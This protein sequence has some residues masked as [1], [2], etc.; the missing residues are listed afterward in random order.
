MSQPIVS[1]IIPTKN[2]AATLG[3]CL[4]SIKKQTY[5]AAK[6]ELIVIDNFSSD[7]TPSLAKKTADIFIQKGPERSAQ[8]NYGVKKAHGKY[9]MIIDSDMQLAPEVIEQ[10]VEKIGHTPNTV[11]II[12]PEESFGEGFWAQC[13]QLERSFYVGVA[14][15]EAARF[16]KKTDFTAVGGYDTNMVSGEDWDLSQR[17]EAK[18]T[19]AR[20]DAYIHHNEG[21]ISLFQT[22]KKKYYYAQLFANY[23]RK[24]GNT[25]NVTQQMSIVGRYQLF[26]SNPRKLFH[27][28]ILGIGMLFMK[29]CEFGFGGLGYLIARKKVS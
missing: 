6:I 14:Y 16:F 20:I 26:F 12:M 18:G 21:H 17:I 24:S 23:T 11:G 28:P 22:I 13:K 29:T 8:R 1:V 2:S 25:H 5:S 15:M 3:D 9:V 27:N 7:A 10:C 4:Q 19:L